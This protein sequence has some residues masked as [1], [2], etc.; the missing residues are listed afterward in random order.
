MIF[1]VSAVTS[2][3]WRLMPEPIPP[4]CSRWQ[5]LLRIE[6]SSASDGGRV[7]LAP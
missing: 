6:A 1:M 3:P 2:S 4:L 5:P 7:P